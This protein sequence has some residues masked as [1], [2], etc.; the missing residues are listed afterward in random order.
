VEQTN[1][2]FAGSTRVKQDCYPGLSRP[3]LEERPS[4]AKQGVCLRQGDVA[5][6]LQHLGAFALLTGTEI[7]VFLTSRVG[8]DHPKVSARALVLV[9]DACRY[10]HD[11]SHLDLDRFS[12][13]PSE[14]EARVTADHAQDLMGVRVIVVIGE[15]AVD[16]CA[17]PTIPGEQLLA[18]RGITLG[19]TEHLRVDEERQRRVVWDAAVVLE[20]VLLY[21]DFSLWIVHSVLPN[22]FLED[23]TYL[24]QLGAHGLAASSYLI[25]DSSPLSDLDLPPVP[26]HL[27]RKH[28]ENQP[29]PEA[30]GPDARQ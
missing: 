13:R 1:E 23:T 29:R 6:V 7:V 26:P 20:E 9:A 10:Y 25:S 17:T 22:I 19:F 12:L 28:L 27:R 24:R 3:A 21:Y 8:T 18:R 2:H 11:V 16:P 5:Y 30:C 4:F 15:D 14:S